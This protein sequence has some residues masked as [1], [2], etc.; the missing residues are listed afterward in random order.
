MQWLIVA[1]DGTDAQAPERDLATRVAADED[2]LVFPYVTDCYRYR[3]LPTLPGATSGPSTGRRG[4][5]G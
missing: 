2:R 4:A 1:R 5:H 3:R